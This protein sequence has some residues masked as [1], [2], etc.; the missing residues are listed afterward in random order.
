MS[1]SL[2]N[3]PIH[4]CRSQSD[5][6]DAIKRTLPPERQTT[7][8]VFES[9]LLLLFHVCTFCGKTGTDIKKFVN[10][11]FLRVTQRC[12]SCK[13]KRVWESQPFIG[14][15]PAGNLLTSAAILFSG[16][17]PTKA[18]RMF[19]ALNC[20]TVSSQTFFRHQSAYL[21][22]AVNVNYERHQNSVLA[23]LREK[24][25]VLAGDGRAD[26]PGHSAK[27]GT[28]SVI[29]LTCN[30][31]VD[32]KLVQ[33]RTCVRA[34]TYIAHCGAASNDINLMRLISE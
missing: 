9:A 27:F 14:K 22:P 25:L 5:E 13:R 12:V 16:S 18:L 21:F 11:S 23:S 29:D 15:M 30:K 2:V 20:P 24:G 4:T 3:A 8:L 32:F 10:G 33:V 17:F 6:G 34:H 1:D 19:S 26:S 28:Y 31:V 7:Y